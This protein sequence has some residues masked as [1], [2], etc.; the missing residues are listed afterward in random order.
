MKGKDVILSVVLSSHD[1]PKAE[2]VL[3]RSK[4]IMPSINLASVYRNLNA[5][6]KE[7]KIRKIEAVGGDRFDKTLIDHAHFQCSVC[8]KVEDLM[9]IDVMPIIKIAGEGGNV[10]TDTEVN[11]RG[12]CAQCKS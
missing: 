6:L 12:V 3:A 4:E 8:G 7:G 2:T 11:F 9:G 5:L 10:I 1:H